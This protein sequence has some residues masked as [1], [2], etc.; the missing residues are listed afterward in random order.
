G[1]RSRTN[2]TH[3]AHQAPETRKLHEQAM[4]VQGGRIAVQGVRRQAQRSGPGRAGQ[5]G[6]AG[7]G[8]G[9][10]RAVALCRCTAHV[11][12]EGELKMRILHAMLL[13]ALCCLPVALPAM[14]ADGDADAVATATRLLDHMEAGEYEAAS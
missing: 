12:Q 7:L 8:A 6:R 3:R 10:R 5:A 1:C 13:A 14:A 4:A 9:L 2:R 11:P